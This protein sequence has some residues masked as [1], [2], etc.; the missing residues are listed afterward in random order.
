[1][2]KLMD[3]AEFYQWFRKQH[4]DPYF[5]FPDLESIDDISF[6]KLTPRNAD[7]LY[8]LFANDT[9]TFVDKRFKTPDAARA[10]AQWLSDWGPYSPK[11]GSQDYLFSVEGVGYAGVLHLYDLSLETFSN[12]HKRVWIGFATTKALRRR[13]ITTKAVRHLIEA[14]F[15]FYPEVDFIHAMTDKKN[16]V[17]QQ[18]IL[19]CGFLFDP[20]ERNSKNYNFYIFSRPGLS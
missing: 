4:P 5:S 6:E 16:I 3:D 9:S 11:H 17:A 18:F 12:N 15:S 13:C 20:T 2:S 14:I 8:R 1:M 10:Y 19:H 7:A